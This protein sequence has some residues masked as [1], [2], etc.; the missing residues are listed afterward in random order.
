MQMMKICETSRGYYLPRA[1]A[2]RLCQFLILLLVSGLSQKAWGV[3]ENALLTA[4]DPVSAGRFGENVSVAGNW[5]LVGSPYAETYYP[6]ISAGAAYVYERDSAT[7]VWNG[8]AKLVASDPVS[9]AYLGSSVFITEEF[10]FVG[11]EGAKNSTGANTG[12][13]YIFRRDAETGGWDE[14]D[15]LVAS[16]GADGDDFGSSVQLWGGR[17]VVGASG[18]T[19]NGIRSGAAYV[20]ELSKLSGWNESTKLGPS[21]GQE[22]DRFG[23]SVSAG[24]NRVL[25]GTD[26][27]DVVDSGYAHMFEFTN[28]SWVDVKKFTPTNISGGFEFVF[29]QSVSILG[30]RGLIGG[31]PDLAYAIERDTA[32]GAWTIT[33][34]LPASGLSQSVALSANWAVIGGGGS[35][36][37]HVYQL[38]AQ[39]GSW[40]YSQ[41]LTASD[42]EPGERFGHSVAV[43]ENRVAVGSPEYRG[44]GNL[45]GAARVYDLEPVSTEPTVIAPT[46]DLLGTTETFVWQPNSALVT[47]WWLFLGSSPGTSDYYYSPAEIPGSVLSE[48]VTN[49]PLAGSPLYVRLW[50]QVVGDPTWR[51]VDTE[52]TSGGT[53][54]SI[55]APLPGSQ[56]AGSSETFTWPDNGATEYLLAAGSSVGAWDYYSSGKV[57]S[58]YSVTATGLPTD[59][60]TVYVRLWYRFGYEGWL[61]L[62]E[63]Y[64]AGSL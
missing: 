15:K 35:G 36:S 7:G 26:V 22:L 46:Y 62:D 25:I 49:I 9:R 20:F 23:S 47:K 51:W 32:S 61:F 8:V 50:Y 42:W 56:L 6:V 52:H 41:M 37:M 14:V 13:V 55:T 39:S 2:H 44:N 48:T 40:I 11:A 16:D 29:G 17:L 10:A 63:T 24:Q 54:L 57:S 59:G 19:Y 5:S 60:S 21:D 31:A 27:H 30:D 28:G 53:A 1:M 3:E 34:E 43:A 64:T 18:A 38:D 45:I 12:A 4:S 33:Q 58:T